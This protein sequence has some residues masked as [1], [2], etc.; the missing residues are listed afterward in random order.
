MSSDSSEEPSCSTVSTPKLDD[1]LIFKEPL[2]PPKKVLKHGKKVL[3]EDEYLE[4]MGKIIQR[5]FFPDLEKLKAQNAYLDAVLHNDVRKL[6]EVYA[7]YS[8]GSKPP[9]DRHS[10]PATFETPVASSRTSDEQFE[11]KDPSEETAFN[12]LDKNSNKDKNLSLDQFLS[13]HT[14]EDNESFTEIMKKAEI[15]HR[16]KHPWLYKEAENPEEERQRLLALPSTEEQKD[17]APKPLNLDTWTFKDKNY[18]MYVPDGVPLTPE[19]RLEMSKRRQSINHASTRLE[20]CPFNEEQNKET[21]HNV[22]QMQ[23]RTLEGKIDVDGKEVVLGTTPKVNGFSFVKTPSPAPGVDESPLITWGEIEGTP[24]RLDGGDTPLRPGAGT[25]SF[26]IAEP[27]K[28]ERLALALAEK[29]SERH[30]NKKS[31]A[32]EAAKRL[33]SPSPKHGGLSVERLSTMSPAAQRF[34]SSHLKTCI[35]SDKALQASYSPASNRSNRSTRSTTPFLSPRP[36]STPGQPLRIKTPTQN[37]R[38]PVKI[39]SKSSKSANTLTDDLLKLNLPK[40]PKASD[41]F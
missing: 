8:S 14:S 10:S 12:K 17:P 30:R 36:D 11:L 27:P 20:H 28:R 5:D 7:K 13:A 37:P 4:R 9:T 2:V 3:E 38:A 40:R 33:A 31:K 23:A 25:A 24:I 18:I 35:G 21:L 19:E 32:M 29:A 39:S 1:K 26:R 15:R 22:A 6:Q 41:F 16:L 34:I